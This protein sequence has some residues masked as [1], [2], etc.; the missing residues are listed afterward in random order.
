MWPCL[1]AEVHE[2]SYAVDGTLEPDGAPFSQRTV[3]SQGS[4]VMFQAP[5]SPRIPQLDI[6]H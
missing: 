5:F 4:I 6:I 3:L 1:K 2:M